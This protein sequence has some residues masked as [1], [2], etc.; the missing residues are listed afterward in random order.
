M[1]KYTSNCNIIDTLFFHRHVSTKIKNNFMFSLMFP[2]LHSFYCLLKLLK[3]CSNFLMAKLCPIT[4]PIMNPH[5]YPIIMTTQ[6]NLLANF[7]THLVWNLVAAV[8]TSQKFYISCLEGYHTTLSFPNM[9]Y[10][11]M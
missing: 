5:P 10:L 4:N 11:E 9:N 3:N 1:L 7:E 2:L 8:S 6:S